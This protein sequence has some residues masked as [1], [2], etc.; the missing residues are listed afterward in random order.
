[1]RFS[2]T[3]C[4]CAAAILS[5]TAYA[6]YTLRGPEGIPALAKRREEIQQIEKRNVELSREIERR[7]QKINR[8]RE[9]PA[10]QELQIRKQR[11]LVRPGEKVFVLQ[12]QPSA[13]GA[14]GQQGDGTTR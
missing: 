12:D 5:V 6:V 1:M 8:L 9:N 13:E 3:L 7:R 10:E 2:L 11:K 14:A 4:A